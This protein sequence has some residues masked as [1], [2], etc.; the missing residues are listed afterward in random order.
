MQQFLR[1]AWYLIRR[2]RFDEDLREELEF[3]R[4]SIERELQ[5]RGTESSEAHF[6]ARRAIGSIALAQDQSRDVWTPRSLQGL[7]QDVRLA[8]RTLRGTPVVTAVAVLSLAL[9]IGANTAIFSLVDALVLRALPVKD[10]GRLAVLDN[11]S[12]SNPIW[13]QMRALTAFD[14]SF[15]WGARPL[16]VTDEDETIPVNAIWASG[17]MFDTLGVP[18]FIGRTLTLA[19]DRRGASTSQVAV[20][21]YTFW[22]RHLAAAPDA[23]G[24]TLTIERVP[25]TIIGVTGPDFLGPDVGRSYDV[26]IPI[27]AEPIIQGADESWLDDRSTWWLQ[28]MVP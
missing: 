2:R 3:H 8:F 28:I 1:R 12:W 25:F 10:P 21:S 24:R 6:A 9:G 26:A 13:E 19:D 27:A 18:A 15:A 11:G 17:S 16:S 5:E 4:A 23:V 7:G 20:I 14:G 22:Q